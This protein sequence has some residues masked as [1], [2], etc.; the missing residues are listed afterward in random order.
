MK[1]NA[2]QAKLR[3]SQSADI[4]E[5]EADRVAEQLTDLSLDHVIPRTDK[6]KEEEE[7]VNRNCKVC[8][9]KKQDTKG[10]AISR[11]PSNESSPTV[12]NENASKI[13]KDLSSGGSSLDIH[14]RELMNSRF[15]YDFSNVKIHTGP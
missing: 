14:T 6:R 3:I 4:Y 2:L 5:Q 11:K 9:M 13:S 15:G 12:S 8:E 10:L 1:S 7:K